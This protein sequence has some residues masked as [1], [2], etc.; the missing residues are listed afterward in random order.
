[1]KK[2][3]NTRAD[4]PH[5]LFLEGI[6]EAAAIL[7]SGGTILH[8]NKALSKLLGKPLARIIGAPLGD[9]VDA[10][11]R[12]S[13][14]SMLKS[15][16]ASGSRTEVVLDMPRGAAAPVLL[17][18][19]PM[20]TKD[21]GRT[22]L[23]VTDLRG[24]KEWHIERR[25][26]ERA[27][28]A[29]RLRLFEVLETL[30]VYVI[31]LSP[32]YHVPFANKF[33]RDRF[34]DSRG[35]RC[36]EYLFQ[37]TE[38]CGNCESYKVMRTGK[39]HHWEWTGPDGRT[40]DIHDF[41][42]R[43]WDGSPLVMEM[44]IDVTEQKRAQ[45][46]QDRASQHARSL[47]E[48]S[49]DPL[50]TISSEGKI[51]DVN[52]ATIKAT[53]IPRHKLIGTDFSSYFTE[54]RKAR[55]GYRQAFAKGS[56]TDYPLTLRRKD[57]KTMDVLYNAAVYRHGDGNVLGV[58][59]AARDMTER[60]RAEE[61]LARH[62]DHLEELVKERTE[63]LEEFARQR[64][65]A[66]DAADMGWWHYD[67]ITRI[68]WWDDRYKEIFGVKEDSR[69]N[70]EILAR[71]HPE[72]LPG[73]WAEVEAALD[74]A[75]PRVYSAE[76]RIVMPDGSM[77]W[78][79]AHGIASF[80]GE[81]KNRRATSLVGTVADITERK[82]AD[83]AL[84]ASEERLHR[85]NEL[86]EAVTAGA[87]VI[88]ASID[89]DFRYAYFNEP[90]H[91][92]LKRLTGK[93]TAIGMSLMEAM[94]DMP[95]QRDIALA[96]WGRALK[97]ETISQALEFGDPGRY[98]RYYSTRHTPI[99]DAD[100]AIVGA[101]EVTTDIT[102]FMQAQ[103]A[104][105]QK[106]KDL[107]RA[108]AV[109]R[110]G[111]WRLDVQR[112]ELMW[113]DENHRIFGISKGPPL[114]YETFLST[115]HPDDRDFVDE[116]W[117]AALSGE[118][119]DIEHRIVVDGHIR[120]VRER[121]ELEFGPAGELLGGFGT[122]Q[123]ITERKRIEEEIER[124]R[125]WLERIADTTP[126]I[127]FVLDIVSNRNVYEN[128]SLA[129][130]LG[131]SPEET[132][133][134]DDILEKAVEPEDLARAAEFYR[135]MAD[136]KPGEIRVLTH[137][138]RHRD[139]RTR[140]LEN[141]VTPFSWDDDGELREVIGISHD[142]TDLKL[143]HEVLQRDRETFERLV[144]ER[145]A[146]LVEIH[147]EL[148]K[149]RHLSDIG[150]LAS[151]VAHEL[152]NPLGVIKTAAYNI[153]RKKQGSALDKHLET[154]NRKIDESNQIINNLLMYSRIKQPAYETVRIRD[155]LR[156]S[157][158]SARARNDGRSVTFLDECDPVKNVTATID[159]YQI[160]EVMSNILTNAAQAIPVENAGSVTVSAGAE[161]GLL[162]IRV[163]D[164]GVGIDPESL[165][166]VFEPFFTSKSKGTG[167]GL[168]LCRELVALHN[169]SIEIE[170]ELGKGTTVTVNLPLS[171]GI[172]PSLA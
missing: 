168:S 73:V 139:G 87:N 61:Q 82:R 92:E 74:P 99:R 21:G 7:A 13:F 15:K 130:M 108:Q 152:R 162:R 47:I 19:R 46:A 132:R 154:I 25:E 41:P 57:G 135:D 163:S 11:H 138:A 58:F 159:P 62:R 161:D 28:L 69:P 78:I 145:T 160:A 109:A 43:D 80:E 120:W 24:T 165:P 12:K 8:A 22:F 49:L 23:I 88:I 45:E 67:P 95:D 146:E 66:L 100:G 169:G 110:T 121:A 36:F 103:E 125:L 156:E 68:S 129:E 102:E 98:R 83:E 4:N 151:T 27:A 79:E 119:Y 171:P 122:T 56:V 16:R 26:I 31:L 64:Q 157:V 141:R 116:R 33:F 150:M 65:L 134:A 17:S 104:L 30:P 54:P 39:R 10:A 84:R 5:R 101:G 131:Y 97:G 2:K 50:V 111:S 44:G 166:R 20:P 38:P 72:D 76:Y 113:S 137:R 29:E 127:I 32:D 133:E 153:N 6:P 140:W 90:H 148:D 144:N 128:R 48:A 93:G 18:S 107:N 96:L 105:R 142:I 42:F 117:Q 77:K 136:A 34:G 81:G 89:K 170:S 3:S 172:R 167:L 59:A 124:S 94:A 35:K 14:D 143:A 86:L 75:S 118:A 155:L 106:E 70:E 1:M 52:E 71:L 51:T 37:R 63:K 115:I 123:D 85:A 60:K 53:G 158:E 55:S 149:A 112:N 126:D 40:Y 9:F 147:N 114:T 91:R 164:T